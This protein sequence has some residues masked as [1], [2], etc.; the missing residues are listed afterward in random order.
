MFPTLNHFRSSQWFDQFWPK[1]K[2]IYLSLQLSWGDGCFLSDFDTNNTPSFS[3]TNLIVGQNLGL[4]STI[5][6]PKEEPNFCRKSLCRK[7]IFLQSPWF[8]VNYLFINTYM[9][10]FLI[11][12]FSLSI[13]SFLLYLN[14]YNL[15]IV[16][17]LYLIIHHVSTYIQNYNLLLE[18]FRKR[19][20]PKKTYTLKVLE[21]MC[22]L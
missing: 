19:I 16:C 13:R 3:G 22:I 6:G 11:I 21:A 14:S 10:P 17:H 18:N 12:C 4:R 20:T 2:S 1:P 9:I 15:L 7:I 8:F 5:F